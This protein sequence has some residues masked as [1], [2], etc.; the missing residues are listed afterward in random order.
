MKFDFPAGSFFQNNNSVLEPLTDY[1]KEAIFGVPSAASPLS[2][3]AEESNSQDLPSKRSIATPTHLVDTYCGSGLF[4]ITLSPSFKHVA[5]IEIDA[6]AIACAKNNLTLNNLDITYESGKKKHAF[7]AGKSEDIF[8]SVLENSEEP[9]PPEKTVVIIDPPRKGCDEAFIDQVVTYV[10]V[11]QA[12]F[13]SLFS[14]AKTTV[15]SA[16][17][18][19]SMSR[20]TFIPKR[21]T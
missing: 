4:G 7:H 12:Q 15:G 18:C 17:R 8:A 11:I 19:L 20:A 2:G 1:V 13:W 16:P 5:G 9:F 21:E 10:H 14:C 3:V 6:N